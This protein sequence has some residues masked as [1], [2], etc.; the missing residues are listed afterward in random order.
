MTSVV[1]NSGPLIALGGIDRLDLLRD[2]F[3]QVSV[4]AQVVAEWRQGGQRQTGLD[5]L[6]RATWINEVA[7][8]TQ[9]DPLLTSLLDMGEA[10]AIDLAKRSG[11]SLLLMDEAK[12][13][14][15]AR[16]IFGLQVIGTGRV[17]V[18]AKRAKLIIE[19]APLITEIRSNGYWLSDKIVTE[20]QRQAG[21]A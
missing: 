8:T 7:A 1:C 21:E 11:P 2:L 10:F 13:R 12:G 6:Q 19:V 5:A 15:I 16:D 9:P 17:L 18:E 20:I 4:P 3:E 14:R